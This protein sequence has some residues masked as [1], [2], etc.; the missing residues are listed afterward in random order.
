[1]IINI[2]PRLIQ[3]SML[4]GEIYVKDYIHILHKKIPLG[5]YSSKDY[6][7][8]EVIY[9]LE[10]KLYNTPKP[11]SIYIGNGMYVVDELVRHM[12]ISTYPNVIIENNKLIASRDISMYDEL[13]LQLL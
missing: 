7:P 3:K 4:R 5:L 8:F 2:C 13:M 6:K 11:N 10:G 9:K 12:N 1:M